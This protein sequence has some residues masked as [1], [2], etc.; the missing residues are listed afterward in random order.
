MTDKKLPEFLFAVADADGNMLGH[1]SYAHGLVSSEE[2]AKLLTAVHFEKVSRRYRVQV[3][4]LPVNSILAG[5]KQPPISL[6][7]VLIDVLYANECCSLTVAELPL[8]S[9]MQDAETRCKYC[10]STF[11]YEFDEERARCVWRWRMPK[12][13]AQRDQSIM[14]LSWVVEAIRQ[15]NAAADAE[16]EAENAAEMEELNSAQRSPAWGPWGEDGRPLGSD[17]G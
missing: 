16:A 7:E 2:R 3:R 17:C 9:H 5:A 15:G 12:G 8:A 4:S 14:S 10:G 11:R 1:V 6:D 13:R